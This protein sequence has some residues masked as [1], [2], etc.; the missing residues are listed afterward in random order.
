M[1]TA[2]CI[3]GAFSEAIAAQVSTD[4][5]LEMCSRHGGHGRRSRPERDI[6]YHNCN[7]LREPCFS[8][9]TERR[10]DWIREL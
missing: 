8:R 3:E 2:N 10:A 5:W 7:N 4:F 1:R 9:R 6:L